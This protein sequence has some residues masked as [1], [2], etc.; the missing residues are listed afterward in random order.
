MC[1][2]SNLEV[3]EAVYVLKSYTV[4]RARDNKYVCQELLICKPSPFAHN[5]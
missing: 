1:T 5:F 4:A 2:P 3:A